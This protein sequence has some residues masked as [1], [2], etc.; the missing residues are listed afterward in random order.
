LMQELRQKGV[1]GEIADK[2]IGDAFSEEETSE[3]TLATEVAE[4]WVERQNR[5]VAEAL[6]TNDRSP[7]RERGRR[8]LHAFLSRRGFTSDAINSALT[9][10]LER[11]ADLCAADAS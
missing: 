4:K 10:A 6:A 5:S 8:R 2:A 7:E 9:A 11:A 1:P 3:Q